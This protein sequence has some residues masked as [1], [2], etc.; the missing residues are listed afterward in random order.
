MP[1]LLQLTGNAVQTDDPVNRTESVT[2]KVEI[3]VLKDN[4]ITI[5]CSLLNSGSA[6]SN[7]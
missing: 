2:S 3:Y 6:N 5:Q 7:R 4:K 1:Y